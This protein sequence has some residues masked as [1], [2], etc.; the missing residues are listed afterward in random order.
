[1]ACFL[2]DATTVRSKLTLRRSGTGVTAAA[3]A[4]PDLMRLQ[5]RFQIQHFV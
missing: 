3:T 5:A 1:M 4:T 2:E